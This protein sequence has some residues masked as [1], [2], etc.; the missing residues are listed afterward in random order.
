[1]V[2]LDNNFRFFFRT[3]GKR[4]LFVHAAVIIPIKEG[5]I[6]HDDDSACARIHDKRL[7][8]VRLVFIDGFLENLFNLLLEV[9]I[10][11]KHDAPAI[12]GLFDAL[13]IG[14]Y[15]PAKWVY[16]GINLSVLSAQLVIK[17]TLDAVLRL[18]LN[19]Q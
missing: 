3:H 9:T 11:R 18:L 7:S 13:L 6:C 8:A 12:L 4:Q 1:M 10:N 15:L 2:N 16:D 17:N 14:E 19:G 5:S